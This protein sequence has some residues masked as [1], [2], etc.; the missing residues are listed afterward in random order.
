[1]KKT[2]LLF[3][4]FFSFVSLVS[5]AQVGIGTQTPAAG[6][7]LEINSADK[8]LLIP[9]VA[10]TGSVTSPTEGLLVYQ[11]GGTAGFYVYKGGTWVRL[12]TTAD[13]P[14]GGGGGGAIIPFASGVPVTMATILG[15][16]QGTGALLGFGNSYSGVSFIGGN[17]DLTGFSGGDI[18]KAFSVPRDGTITSLSGYFSTTNAMSLLGT[19]ITIQAQLYSSNAPTNTFTPVPGAIVTLSPPLTGILPVGATSS[20]LTTGL[21]IPVT[22]GTRLLLVYSCTAAGLSLVNTAVGYA[23]AGVGIN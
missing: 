10:S 12:A 11:T 17:I 13:I 9:R 18:N 3:L 22:A 14:A 8:G 15:G 1:M 2:L 7:Q 6:A 4:L 20:G 5:F 19:T 23:S 16:L 21:N